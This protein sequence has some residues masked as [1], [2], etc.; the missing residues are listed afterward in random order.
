MSVAVAPMA[1]VAPELFKQCCSVLAL[2]DGLW[3]TSH[4]TTFSAAFPLLPESA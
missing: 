2:V 4:S 3:P 1:A